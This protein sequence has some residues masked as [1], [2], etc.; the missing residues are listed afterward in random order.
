MSINERF[1]FGTKGVHVDQR[2][3][4]AFV[5][6]NMVSVGSPISPLSPQQVSPHSDNCS[7]HHPP[8]DCNCNSV[9]HMWS[10]N[11][12]QRCSSHFRGTYIQGKSSV[13]EGVPC[14]SAEP[15]FQGSHSLDGSY[16]SDSPDLLQD[17]PSNP[18]SVQSMELPGPGG[19]KKSVKHILQELETVLMG[20]EYDDTD[21]VGSVSGGQCSIQE[22][23]WKNSLDGLIGNSFRN[24]PYPVEEQ[25]HASSEHIPYSDNQQYVKPCTPNLEDM[26]IPERG[27]QVV[28]KHSTFRS[29]AQPFQTNSGLQ[30]VGSGSAVEQLLVM[31]A[32]AI[33]ENDFALADV[34]MARLKQAVSIY[35]DPLQRLAAYMAEGLVARIASSGQGIYKSLKCKEAPA[36]DILSAMQKMYEICPYFKFGYMSANGAIAEAF[37]DD[38]K[39]HILD[40][41]IAH[42]TQWISLIQALANRPGGPPFV[43]IT[44]VDD[45]ESE[46]GPAGGLQTVG[47]TLAKI[48]EFV[49]VPFQFDPVAVKISELQ[50]SAIKLKSD[51]ALAVNFAFQLHHMPDESVC[52]TNPRDRLLRMV[53][54][55]NPKVLTLVEQEVNTNTAPFLPRFLETL[56][57]YSAIFESIDVALP[58]DSKDRVNVEQQCLAR[59]IVN[60][61]AC[62]GA[63]RVER[64]EL[65][66]KWK[67]RMMMAGFRPHPL[68]SYV[69]NTI[70]VLLELYNENYRLKEEEGAL[71]LGWLDRP[72]VVA[73]AWH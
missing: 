23:E 38:A 50:A 65:M 13:Y 56:N 53:K 64:H 40:I 42:G 49:G 43:R 44:G 72:L 14:C 32:A 16:S 28:S 71:F 19:N 8:L 17:F 48:A 3:R 1:A 55:M 11:S 22:E 2:Q 68:S 57:Y 58:R 10:D 5:V 69:N 31:C 26:P 20:P 25:L 9:L 59:D 29:N 51:E 15:P 33:A 73:S 67:A 21:F 6:R 30:Y 70:K 60:I 47:Q 34:I 63:E 45:P 52:I 24:L 54:S 41:Q 39:V 36:A 66:G 4:P 18:H 37:K 35:G 46:M 27:R 7:Q 61:I 12:I 62:E